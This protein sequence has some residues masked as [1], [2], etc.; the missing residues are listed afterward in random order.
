MSRSNNLKRHESICPKKNEVQ[1]EHKNEQLE[2]KLQE[3]EK[4]N[5]KMKEQ[6]IKEKE[7]AEQKQ[8]Q[9]EEQFRMY[10][11]Q[12]QMLL[13]NLNK[14]KIKYNQINSAFVIANFTEAYNLEDLMDP[15]LTEEEIKML[16][17]NS[18]IAGCYYLLKSRCI[19][20]IEV[21]KRPFH[22]VDIARKKYLIRTNG[23]WLSDVGGE[24]ILNPISDKIKDVWLT[25][26][27]TDTQEQ[28]ISKIEK[29]NEYGKNS[30]K[31]LDYINDHI[32]LKNNTFDD[33]HR[34]K[35][36]KIKSKRIVQKKDNK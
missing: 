32:I 25:R 2:R 8:K 14:K 12:I 31:I 22:L 3:T 4:L 34:K 33:Y 1:L 21:E 36:K 17:D 16:N 10:T 18:P 5:I 7:E 11:E 35:P 19:D 29:M 23:N 15:E 6:F 27:L 30:K 28:L 20:N 26:P 9:T 24:T 13:Q